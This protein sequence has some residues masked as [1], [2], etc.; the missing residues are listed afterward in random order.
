MLHSGWNLHYLLF[1][2]LCFTSQDDICQPLTG[3]NSKI[4]Q[5]RWIK[6][7]IQFMGR[8]GARSC[9]STVRKEYQKK[10][11]RLLWNFQSKGKHHPCWSYAFASVWDVGDGDLISNPQVF[12]CTDVEFHPGTI[13]LDV[14][15]GIRPDGKNRGVEVQNTHTVADRLHKFATPNSEHATLNSRHCD[16]ILCIDT[17]MMSYNRCNVTASPFQSALSLSAP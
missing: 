10:V 5:L 6:Q 12:Q 13:R 2:M 1:A 9:P 4:L 14:F 3:W 17:Y 15:E 11:S 8:R 7:S 16:M